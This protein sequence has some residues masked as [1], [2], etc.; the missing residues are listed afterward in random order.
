MGDSKTITAKTIGTPSGGLGDNPWPSGHPAEG[1]RVAIFAYDV[2]ADGGEAKHRTYHVAP[3]V[4][5]AKEGAITQPYSEPQGITFQWMG[6]GAGTVVRPAASVLGKD[7][8]A[9][10]PDK[11]DAMVQCVVSPDDMGSVQT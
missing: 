4:D 1:E 6:C 11:A 10:D 9:D 3:I 5:E 2:T 7:P 8:L